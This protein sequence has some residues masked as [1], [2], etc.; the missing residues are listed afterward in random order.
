MKKAKFII[1]FFVIFFG[2]LFIGESY[3][4]Y[5]NS[6]EQNFYHTTMYI[7]D[8]T[9]EEEMKNDM[10]K[11]AEDNN[12][13]FF[14][15]VNRI[16]S[17]LLQNFEIYGTSKIKHILNN[18]HDIYE[19]NYI[20]LLTGETRV[21]F[22]DFKDISNLENKI[23]YYLI[24]NEKNINKFKETLIEKYAGNFP[25]RGEKP[26]K[27]QQ[28]Y[29]VW[30]LISIVILLLSLY[31]IIFQKKEN[32]IKISLGENVNLI[33]IKNILLDIGIYI[34]IFIMSIIVLYKNTNVFF[35]MNV[36]IIVFLFFLLINSI[37]YFSLYFNNLKKM[38]SGAKVSRKLLSINYVLKFI[39]IL[40]T[41][42][43]LASNI[44]IIV[45]GY[46][47][48]KQK[49]FF[50][51]YKNYSYVDI[52]YKMKLK[53]DG[54]IE[55]NINKSMFIQEDFY[56][57]FYS[58]FNAL[59]LANVTMSGLTD[60][61][62]LSSKNTLE[63][64]KKNIKEINREV[65]EKDFYFLIPE[66]FKNDQS[67]IDELN[68]T[69]KVYESREL[70]Y[71]YDVIY[72]SDNR[73]IISIDEQYING[74]KLLKNPLI[75]YK[76]NID[77]KISYR[78][79]KRKEKIINYR[80]VMYNI[81]DEEFDEFLIK[82]DLNDERVSKTNVL[83]KYLYQLKI[84][85]RA[86]FISLILSLLTLIL[87]L[88]LIKSILMLEYEV[89]AIELSVKKILGYSLLEKNSKILWVTIGITIIS[90]IGSVI[91]GGIFNISEGYYLL[92]S[93]TLIAIME[94][95]TIVFYIKRLE[96]TNLQKVLKGGN[97]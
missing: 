89:N 64:L 25:K 68:L 10:L 82:Y 50:E 84:V 61:V 16:E 70:D 83:E 67:I 37:M 65:L 41:T 53:S 34:S 21:K 59:D 2:F 93:G 33:I 12:I 6:F 79:G 52:Q 96:K 71:T 81:L 42:A 95:F 30:I 54:S 5:L 19:K 43:I 26:F 38:L 13:E 31:D 3:Q 8:Y 88:I 9:S 1:S 49:D 63:Y 14:T 57:N 51:K 15:I 62:V 69:I 97:L 78:D 40:L 11:A 80:N 72:Y 87:E 48:Y 47:F 32:S 74:S 27:Y 45:E 18:D 58:K 76:N 66:K 24:G 22:Y 35:G 56:N 85:K 44:A 36:S 4:F 39:S 92:I 60:N 28:V 75:I 20:S 29:S 91:I 77:G 7:Q 23:D 73:E 94:I 90:I 86:V 55:D 17:T 46:K